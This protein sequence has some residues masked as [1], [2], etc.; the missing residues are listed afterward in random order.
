MQAADKTLHH[1]TPLLIKH[2]ALHA[3][4]AQAEQAT[5]KSTHCSQYKTTLQVLPV[6]QISPLMSFVQN[7][8]VPDSCA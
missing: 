4:A 3:G 1:V 6:D 8:Q 7:T 2:I 5:K